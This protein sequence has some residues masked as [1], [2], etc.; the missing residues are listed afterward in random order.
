M[1][2]LWVKTD[3]LHPTTR[4]GQIRTLEMLK[5]LHRRHEIHY[6]AFDDG[7]E[8]EGPRRSV[9]YCSRAYR[10]PHSVPPRRSIRFAGQLLRGLVSPLPVPVARYV[11]SGMKR[12]IQKLVSEEKFD[13]VV[14]DFLF[15]APNIP[16]ISRAV[17]FQHNVESVIWRRHAAEAR[18]RAK[19]AYFRL[20]ARRMEN[21]E[22]DICRRAGHIVAVSEVDRKAMRELFGVERISTVSTGVDIEYFAPPPSVEAKAELIF[23]GSMDWLP[24]I[25]AIEYFAGEILPLI[26]KQRPECRVIVAGRRPTAALQELARRE[27]HITL[28]GTVPDVRPYLW[29]S[30]V[31]IVPLRIGG[32][33]RL[34]IFEAIA[35]GLPVVSTSVGAEGLP[36]E[37]G[38]QIAIAD[39]PEAFA[40]ACLKLLTH[41]AMRQR[42]AQDAWDFVASRFSWEAVTR[43]FEAA[44]E[45]GPRPN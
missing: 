6:L 30:T 13:S 26:Q 35:A 40:D 39:T 25:D 41:A 19:K 4:G 11:S 17:L 3:F 20:Q 45:A 28:T 14:C 21:F 27:P 34:K 29:E 23:V 9:E 22:R 33:T 8:S 15:P 43:D 10:V 2:I 18:H 31:S 32:G 12:Q 44:L 24:N 16:D 5:A 37:N 42:R 7:V 1:K 36:L 38:R